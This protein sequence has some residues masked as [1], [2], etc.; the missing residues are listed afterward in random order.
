M[1]GIYIH[2]PFCLSKCLYCGFYSVANTRNKDLY[3]NILYTIR[4]GH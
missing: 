2:V 4:N 1:S 3:V